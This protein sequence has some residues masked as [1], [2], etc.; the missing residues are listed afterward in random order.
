MLPRSGDIIVDALSKERLMIVGD[1][2]RNYWIVDWAESAVGCYI[3]AKMC[4]LL[5]YWKPDN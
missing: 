5:C 3:V 1:I 4:R 2:L